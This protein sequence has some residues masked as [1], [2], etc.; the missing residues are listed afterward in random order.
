MNKFIENFNRIRENLTLEQF[1]K[2]YYE[3]TSLIGE[4]FIP[5]ELI[6]KNYFN[7]IKQLTPNYEGD[8]LAVV[9]APRECYKSTT[10][11]FVFPLWLIYNSMIFNDDLTLIYLASY[12][13]ENAYQS[14][15]YRITEALKNMDII[16]VVKSDRYRTFITNNRKD[17][18]INV[19][20]IGNSLRSRNYKGKRPQLIIADD[21]DIP[22]AV[23]EMKSRYRSITMFFEDWIPAREKGNSFILVVGNLESKISIIQRLLDIEYTHKLIL[24]YKVNNKYIRDN[25][26]EE[27]EKRTRQIMGEE[28]FLRQYNHQLPGDD[29]ELSK[30]KAVGNKIILIDPG[31][32]EGNF[33][34]V[35]LI[36]NTIVDVFYTSYNRYYEIFEEI[37]KFKPD[38]IIYEAN[39]FQVFLGE[40]LRE[41]FPFIQ[42]EELRTDIAQSRKTERMLKA[43]DYLKEGK[44]LVLDENVENIIKEEISKIKNNSHVLDILGAYIEEYLGD[45]KIEMYQF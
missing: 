3:F 7:F 39:S 28:G 45:F 37:S 33:V 40:K 8:I 16:N 21:I 32:N 15:Y 6:L 30:G 42:V 17:V 10:F 5:D 23:D 25:W 12:Q 18:A 38:I 1:K 22:Y 34:M 14:I 31:I 41:K 35:F 11:S 19:G 2:I 9:L 24:P 4:G 43:Y 36:G 20:H 13:Y 44:L 29:I 27:W 26:N